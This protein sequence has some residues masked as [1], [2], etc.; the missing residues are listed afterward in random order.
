MRLDTTPVTGVPIPAD[1]PAGPA[2]AQTPTAP[3]AEPTAGSVAARYAR[4][5]G[6]LPGL[7]DDLADQ[8]DHY[9]LGTPKRWPTPWPPR[10]FAARS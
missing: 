8:H 6:A 5:R 10:R 4:F 2:I 3:A 9:R 7:P 1:P